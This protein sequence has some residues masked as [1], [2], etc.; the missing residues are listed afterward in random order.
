[1][2]DFEDMP[3]NPGFRHEPS[4]LPGPKFPHEPG[5][6]SLE[7]LAMEAQDKDP[8]VLFVDAFSRVPYRV[9]LYIIRLRLFIERL[10]T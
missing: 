1:M 9:Q 5:H 8:A 3:T 10:L 6:K 4:M 2:T 7:Q